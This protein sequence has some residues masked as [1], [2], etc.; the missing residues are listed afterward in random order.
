MNM[1]ARGAAVLVVAV[2][3]IGALAL[4]TGP[5]GGIGGPSPTA[6]PTPTPTPTTAPTPLVF[7]SARYRYSITLPT[8]WVATP[9][10]AMWDGATAPIF[11]DPV[12]DAFGP[13]GDVGAFVS[14]APTTS[15]LGAWVAD[16]IATN[17]RVNTVDSGCSQLRDAGLGQVD[18]H[19][20]PARHACWLQELLLRQ[21]GVH[22]RQRLRV[23]IR[24]PRPV[25]YEFKHDHD[26]A[27]VRR[28]P[29]M[30]AGTSTTWRSSPAD[31]ATPSP[32][33]VISA[34][35]MRWPGWPQSR[36]NPP[37]SRPTLFGG[38]LGARLVDELFLTVAPQ[39]AGRTADMPRLALVDGLAYPAGGAPWA[40][41]DSIRRSGSHLFLRYALNDPSDRPPSH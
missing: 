21:H 13:V 23:S 24:F 38:L 27:G 36:S 6:T 10:R 35:P 7:T 20:R 28:L 31:A 22:G 26:H 29:L 18:H 17:A 32:S 19:R 16:G 15:S 14:A 1:F 8:G 3:A 34:R 11:N 5:S 40:R 12:V 25:E 33:T 30:A 4:L 41:L 9:A 39:V 2:V 37:T